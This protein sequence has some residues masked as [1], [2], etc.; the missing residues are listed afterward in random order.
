VLSDTLPAKALQTVL[1]Y[2]VPQ[3]PLHIS[4]A[5]TLTNKNF[6]HK[7]QGESTLK[8]A[9]F[10]HITLHFTDPSALSG[11]HGGAKIAPLLLICKT[12][13]DCL[14]S[15]TLWTYN[16][17][18]RML[19]YDSLSHVINGVQFSAVGSHSSAERKLRI[20]QCSICT[21]LHAI[22]T[23]KLS[24]TEYKTVIHNVSDSI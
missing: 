18:S 13:T 4:V 19:L 3:K 24:L 15:S 9:L 16:S 17:Y 2:T 10:S 6:W 23:N 8:D 20:L 7:Y 12:S 14:I 22:C 11:I 5:A 21:V 1:N